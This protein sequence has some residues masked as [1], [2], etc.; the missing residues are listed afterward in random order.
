MVPL[1]RRGQVHADGAAIRKAASGRADVALDMVGRAG[2]SAATEA[3]LRS[4]R[5]GGHFVMMGVRAIHG[6]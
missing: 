3:A 6:A 4:P 5:R 2:S 1:V